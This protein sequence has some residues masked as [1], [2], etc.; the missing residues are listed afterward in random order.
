[1]T[2]FLPF[3]KAKKTNGLQLIWK[4]SFFRHRVVKQENPKNLE[5][6]VEVGEEDASS[7]VFF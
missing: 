5:N 6:Y 7:M 4:K 1:M 3:K 2:N